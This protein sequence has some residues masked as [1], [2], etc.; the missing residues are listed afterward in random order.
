MV[1]AA[2]GDDKMMD[3]NLE[4]MMKDSLEADHPMEDV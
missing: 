4:S 3:S 1:D 2:E